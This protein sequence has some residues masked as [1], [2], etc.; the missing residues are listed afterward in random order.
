MSELRIS[1]KS[2]V[3]GIIN[4][5]PASKSVSNRV[6]VLDA[7]SGFSSEISNLSEARDTVLMNAL[8]RSNER[9]INVMDAGTTMRFLTAFYA[10]S[11]TNRI[12]TGTDRMKERPIYPLVDALRTIG[13][14]IRYL[15]REGYPPLEI[16]GFSGQKAT[17]VFVPGNLSSQYIS[18]LMMIGPAL[19]EGLKIRLTG[20]V[21]SRPYIHIT[22]EII[23]M[24]GGQ[25]SFRD[26]VIEIMPGGLKSVKYSIEPDWSAASY[27]FSFC[28]LAENSELTLPGNFESSFQGDQVIC[29]AALLLGVRSVRSAQQLILSKTESE[30]YIE[31]DFNDC[32]DLAQTI[33]PLCAI[34]GINGCFTGLESLRIKETDRILALQQELSKIGAILSEPVTGT[35]QLAPADKIPG[36]IFIKTYHDHRMAMGFAPWTTIVNVTI[37]DRSVVNKSYPGFW[38]DLSGLGFDLK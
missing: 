19:P 6:L 3:T 33:L 29:D 21:G 27:W 10:I 11:G 34:K 2:A 5:L 20:H 22:E 37:E 28:A 14:D 12:M 26:D 1:K 16:L 23:R 25:I 8:V 32:P 38:D 35:W 30:K 15:G 24:F 18:A 9:E 31:W 13:A 17:E 4:N 36:S 7:L